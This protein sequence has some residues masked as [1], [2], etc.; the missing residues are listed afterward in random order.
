MINQNILVMFIFHIQ[1][2]LSF[3]GCLFLSFERSL[4]C[5]KW[6]LCLTFGLVQLYECNLMCSDSWSAVTLA[7]PALLLWSQ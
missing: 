3:Q 2:Y 1:Q 5:P 6:L 7:G 4:L